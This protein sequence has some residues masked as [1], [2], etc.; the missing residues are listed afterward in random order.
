[1][2]AAEAPKQANS[3]SVITAANGERFSMETLEIPQIKMDVLAEATC[4]SAS[5]SKFFAAVT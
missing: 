4:F 5:R 1:M 3:A 2:V